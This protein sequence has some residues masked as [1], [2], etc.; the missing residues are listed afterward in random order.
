MGGV[1]VSCILV[2]YHAAALAVEALRS[3][4]EEA[5]RSGVE[6]ESLVVDNGSEASE[7]DRLRA[8]PVSMIEAGRN[9]GFAAGVNLGVARATG[10]VLLLLNPD[11]RL[12]EDCL[13]AL[14]TRLNGGAGVAGPKFFWDL[15]RRVL[16]PPAERRDR[17]SEILAV[18]AQRG[19]Q[20][21]RRARR[22]WRRHARRHWEAQ[23]PLASTALS[24]A[25]LAISA[26]AWR[27]TGPMD[28]G[29]RLYFEE[30]E[31]LLRAAQRGVHCEYV[32]GA[33]AVHEVG[34]SSQREGEAQAAREAQN[35]FEASARRFRRRRFGVL[36]TTLLER[37]AAASR[38][39]GEARQTPPA[40][41]RDGQLVLGGATELREAS[42]Q[43]PAWLE[44]SPDPRGF[45]AAVERLQSVPELWPPP[46][47]FV[48][49]LS[50]GRWWLRRIDSGG[51]ETRSWRVER[52]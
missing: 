28:D 38:P 13:S 51:R 36:F 14:L 18:L 33:A 44:M 39:Q 1:K 49:A 35:W 29:Y 27:R 32:P 9:L 12:L 6:L 40:Q 42:P 34:R 3:V 45:P 5:G 30:T 8:Q 23:A 41:W 21:S 16:L 15:E 7:R 48:E 4:R 2:H 46:P 26:D 11:S 52:P 50:A 22:R 20:W 10:E 25:C 43:G 24:G 37:L 17:G 31:W 19:E 47:R